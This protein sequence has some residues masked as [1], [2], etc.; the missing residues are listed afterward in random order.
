MDLLS[1]MKESLAVLSVIMSGKTRAFFIT[2][3]DLPSIRKK[4]FIR[5]DEEIILADKEESLPNLV[6][7]MAKAQGRK[8]FFIVVPNFEALSDLL[9]QLDFIPE[10]DFI[11]GKLFLMTAVESKFNSFLLVKEM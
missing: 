11:N 3:A 7:S 9:K 1:V 5:D 8:I 10:R 6:Y 2:S 4:F